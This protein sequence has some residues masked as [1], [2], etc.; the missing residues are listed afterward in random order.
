MIVISRVDENGSPIAQSAKSAEPER[1]SAPAKALTE[2]KLR[3]TIYDLTTLKPLSGCALIFSD[4]E[5]NRAIRT[6]SDLTGT[7][8][9]I[10]PP[11]EGGKGY[12]VAV[13]KNGYSSNYLDPG[14]EGVRQMGA[15]QRKS[16]ARD[17][18]S[19]LSAAP[20]T[21]ESVS[22]KPLVTDFYLAPRP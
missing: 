12:A 10:V 4:E 11:L 1:P 15:A 22:E 9:T 8:R 18:A 21:V 19:T 14:T 17:L 13:E 7:Y 2:W 16:M 6:R 3:G 20:A 5:T